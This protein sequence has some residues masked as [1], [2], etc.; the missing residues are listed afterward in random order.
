MFAK[1]KRSEASVYRKSGNIF[2]GLLFWSAVI[3]IFGMIF[4]SGPSYK[5]S[6]ESVAHS[7]ESVETDILSPTPKELASAENGNVEFS[8]KNQQQ[9]PERNG[10]GDQISSSNDIVQVARK[11]E[12]STVT[13]TEIESAQI[14]KSVTTTSQP[15]STDD[16]SNSVPAGW[17]VQ[18]GAFKSAVNADVER[19]KFNTIQF[20]T[21]IEHG[22]DQFSRVLVG[23]YKSEKDAIQ[24]RSILGK[25]H[26]VKGGIIRDFTG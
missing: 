13:E 22:D 26:N 20:P 11:E 23:P 2:V 21:E 3:G 6:Q 5:I 9:S 19:L 12:L 1:L 14:I 4:L 7:V 25:Q 18:V 8:Q 10:A 15:K 24:A 16:S 17:Y